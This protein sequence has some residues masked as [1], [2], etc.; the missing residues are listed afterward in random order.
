MFEFPCTEQ[1]AP[2]KKLSETFSGAFETLGLPGEMS[3]CLSILVCVGSTTNHQESS[4]ASTHSSKR[5]SLGLS[6]YFAPLLSSSSV[7]AFKLLRII[8]GCPKRLR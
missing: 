8:A 4:E 7:A 3:D 6:L 2:V 5:S 1:Y